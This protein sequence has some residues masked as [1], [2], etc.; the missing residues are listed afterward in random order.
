M[1]ERL[2]H[3]ATHR[4]LVCY[5]RLH[6]TIGKTYGIKNIDEKTSVGS[7]LWQTLGAQGMDMKWWD[8]ALPADK[9]ATPN[10]K[11]AKL[12]R[13][14]GQRPGARKKQLSERPEMA[15]PA[16]AAVRRT[17][18]S[19]CKVPR[20]NFKLYLRLSKAKWKRR[21]NACGNQLCRPGEILRS[22]TP[23]APAAK[24]PGRL[25]ERM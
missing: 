9:D 14:M 2:P 17:G 21:F 22:S 12:V 15:P 20:V 7:M 23:A 24:S 13:S 16:S 11:S 4:A 5:L 10:A 3:D 19:A 1:C 18:G 25:M 8:N 6:P